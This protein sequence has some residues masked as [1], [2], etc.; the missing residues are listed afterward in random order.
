MP[1]RHAPRRRWSLRCLGSPP[2]PDARRLRCLTLSQLPRRTMRAAQP[3][4]PPSRTPKPPPGC[5]QEGCGRPWAPPVTGWLRAA[6]VGAA[7]PPSEGGRTAARCPGRELPR[8][9]I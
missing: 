8:R 3:P 2:R 5:S 6:G 9:W 7:T 4:P 1:P